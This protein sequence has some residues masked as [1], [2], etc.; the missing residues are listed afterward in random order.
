MTARNPLILGIERVH[1]QVG[2]LKEA[3]RD[4]YYRVSLLSHDCP[5]CSGRLA[6]MGPSKARCS[7][8]GRE[9]DPTVVFQRSPCCGAPLELQRTHYACGECG[10]VVPSRFLFDERTFDDQY[11]IEAMRQSRERARKRRERVRLM[12]LGTRSDALC[13]S[14]LPELGEVPGLTEALGSFVEQRQAVPLSRFVGDDVFSM[15]DYRQAILRALCGCSVLFDAIP[16]VGQDA[17]KDRV[18]RFVTLLYMEH[19]HEVTMSQ[20]GER[21]VV[22][23][24]GAET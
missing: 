11:F 22:E 7:A 12:L 5:A 2:L 16:R 14:E 20:Y 3:A 24:C 19:D 1:E 15:E 18:R 21:I 4:F 10:T 6:M 13:I 9:I 17:R 23:K 8:C